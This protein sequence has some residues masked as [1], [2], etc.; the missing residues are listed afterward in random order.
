MTSSAE[1]RALQR[2]FDYLAKG[3]SNVSEL[4]SAAFSGG[5]IS[6]HQRYDCTQEANP[7]EKVI[8]FLGILMRKVHADTSNFQAFVQVLETVGCVKEASTLRG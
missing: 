2:K 5:L 7:Y 1:S 8:K 4:I 6:D 3:I